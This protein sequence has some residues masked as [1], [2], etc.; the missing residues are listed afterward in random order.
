MYGKMSV[1]AECGAA[2]ITGAFF[3]SFFEL[4]PVERERL[5]K[6]LDFTCCLRSKL[7]AAQ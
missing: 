3:L 1:I 4:S 7:T 5:V 6:L 2:I